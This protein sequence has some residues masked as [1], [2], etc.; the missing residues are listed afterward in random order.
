MAAIDLTNRCLVDVKTKEMFVI[1]ENGGLTLVPKKIPK[2]HVDINALMV[3]QEELR[4]MGV[5][6]KHPAVTP[7]EQEYKRIYNILRYQREKAKIL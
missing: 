1:D 2:P 3:R 6:L 4:N 5:K 7:Q